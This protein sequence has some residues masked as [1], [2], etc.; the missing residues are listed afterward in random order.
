[1]KGK[2]LPNH[3]CVGV[4]GDQIHQET[5]GYQCQRRKITQL[6]GGLSRKLKN[7]ERNSGCANQ[8]QGPNKLKVLPTSNTALRSSA[9][10][11]IEKTRNAP[12]YHAGAKEKHSNKIEDSVGSGWKVEE[13][14]VKHKEDKVRSTKEMN[15]RDYRAITQLFGLLSSHCY[16]VLFLL[17]NNTL[18][19]HF[20]YGK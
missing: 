17:P 6:N 5:N 14:K 16:R 7:D 13:K 1:M 19:L 3:W 2:P 8:D 20:L 15:D 4:D 11:T 10:G 18:G 9:Y 12:E